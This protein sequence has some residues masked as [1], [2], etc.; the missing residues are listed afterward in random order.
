MYIFLYAYLIE[1]QT[2]ATSANIVT[3]STI[4]SRMIRHIGNILIRCYA[5]FNTF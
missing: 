5:T 2:S 1:I 3:N 4:F